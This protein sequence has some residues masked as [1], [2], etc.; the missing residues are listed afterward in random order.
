[1]PPLG[2][3]YKLNSIWVIPEVT[4]VMLTSHYKKRPP[5]GNRPL[6]AIASYHQA[7]TPR[8]ID[9]DKYSTLHFRLNWLICLFLIVLYAEG[10]RL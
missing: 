5:H 6:Q 10:S 4:M 8:F 7:R 1:M 9:I 2:D 3:Q